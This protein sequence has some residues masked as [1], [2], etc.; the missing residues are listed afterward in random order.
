M[1]RENRFTYMRGTRAQLNAA[2]AAGTLNTAE[3]YFITDENRFAVGLTA[4][5][6]QTFTKQGEAEAAL[7][8]RLVPTGGTSGQVLA[9]DGSGNAVWTTAA[10]GGGTSDPPTAQLPPRGISFFCSGSPL[11]DEVIGGGIAPYAFNI[12]AAKSSIKALTAATVQT[13]FVIK[14]NGTQIGSATFAAGATVA[15]LSLTNN[16]IAEDDYLSVHAPTNPDSTLANIS[17]KLRA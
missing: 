4:S 3:P 5:T 17:G 13:I 9:R 14:R 10:S 16:A 8:N 12:D 7:A 2:A 15:S 1:A 11:A 6:F